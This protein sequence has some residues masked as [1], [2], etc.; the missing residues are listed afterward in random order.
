VRYILLD[1][2]NGAENELFGKDLFQ[3][4]APTYLLKEAENYV[5]TL[6]KG[7]TA[8]DEFIQFITNKGFKIEPIDCLDNL[9]SFKASN[10]N[11]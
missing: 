3:T 4:N 11:F 8:E 2:C 1:L 7:S 9:D 5:M 6:K 10:N